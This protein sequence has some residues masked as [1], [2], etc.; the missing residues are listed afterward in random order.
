MCSGTSLFLKGNIILQTN[1]DGLKPVRVEVGV[2]DATGSGH[3]LSRLL[4]LLEHL[5]GGEVGEVGDPAA[6]ELG[7]QVVPGQREEGGGTLVGFQALHLVQG[8]G[9]GGKG[10]EAPVDGGLEG[11]EEEE[12]EELEA[13][14]KEERRKI[15][16]K[17]DFALPHSSHVTHC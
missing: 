6:G 10:G 14:G 9:G 1:S 8:E 11:G 2:K 12:G 5:A 3:Q 13:P 4:A 7:H 15:E 16:D 17:E